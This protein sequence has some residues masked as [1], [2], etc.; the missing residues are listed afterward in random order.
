MIELYINNKR[1]YP[2]SS[3]EIKIKNEN[4]Y[5]TSSGSY[6]LEIDIPL[7]MPENRLVFGA[8]GRSDVSKR[9]VHYSARLLAG[10]HEV[11]NGIAKLT[12][13]T[14]KQVKVQLLGGNSETKYLYSDESYVDELEFTD[15]DLEAIALD[16][17]ANLSENLSRD[18][19]VAKYGG[20]GVPFY[21]MCFTTY[22]ETNEITVNPY[23]DVIN[24]R[25]EYIY[26]PHREAPNFLMTLRCVIAC[27]GY[28]V[29][30]CDFDDTPIK[31][32]YIINVR[33]AGGHR[34]N[35][36]KESLPH[37]TVKDYIKQ[38][39]NFLNCTIEFNPAGRTARIIHNS[40]KKKVAE[41]LKIVDEY[42]VEVDEEN[43]GTSLSTAD[44]YYASIP[45]K[46]K[47]ISDFFE[48][49]FFGSAEEVLNYASGLSEDEK[50]KIIFHTPTKSLYW[51]NDVVNLGAAYWFQLTV[52]MR[53]RGNGNKIELK[54]CP[55]S[56]EYIYPSVPN[57]A[58]L[59]TETPIWEV[60]YKDAEFG[61][62][63]EEKDDY[64]R[65]VFCG[66]RGPARNGGVPSTYAAAFRYLPE[67]GVVLP[68][69]TGILPELNWWTGDLHES[70]YPDQ[71]FSIGDLHKDTIKV[72]DAALYRFSFIRDTPPD[73]CGVYLIKNKMYACK[74][75]EYS[76]KDDGINPLMTGE[77]YEIE[78]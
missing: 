16:N 43:A 58:G 7:E 69:E 61:N 65:F 6:T 51:N 25:V 28:H 32:L 54:I 22:D 53:Y 38:V 67:E 14:E 19:M 52:D 71:Q 33:D 57:P 12:G 24:G 2:D 63:N 44:L 34:G 18:E 9:P 66:C 8:I 45:D 37:W 27:M 72:N 46:I 23:T 68:N 62:V 59:R 77:F 76:V 36:F 29:V 78:S 15:L 41:E 31:Y 48:H 5:F 30:S 13:V 73:A 39:E 10:G 17:G 1:V 75:I 3:K 74:M 47:D 40:H 26:G 4:P 20:W 35:V 55:N 11:F 21:Y 70:A 42:T 50:G 56:G 60:I 64:M 49:K